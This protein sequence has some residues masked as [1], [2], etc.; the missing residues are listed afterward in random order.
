LL[1]NVPLRGA[2]LYPILG[3]PEWHDRDLWTPMG[4]WDPLCHRDPAAGRL[5]CEPMAE[6]LEGAAPLEALH[7]AK[8]EAEGGRASRLNFARCRRYAAR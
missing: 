3:M 8:Q 2:C 5:L 1:Q 6:A 7:Q 4:L